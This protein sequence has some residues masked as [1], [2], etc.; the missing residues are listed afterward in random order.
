MSHDKILTFKSTND[1]LIITDLY[2][3][4]AFIEYMI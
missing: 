1:S 2:K 4:I 3:I